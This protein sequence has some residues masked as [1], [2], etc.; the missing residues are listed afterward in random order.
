V[1]AVMAR[2][3]AD[4]HP[5][6]PSDDY[7]FPAIPRAMADRFGN[8]DFHQMLDQVAEQSALGPGVVDGLINNR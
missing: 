4:D 1:D 6:L 8:D 5:P 3:P 7:T 2:K